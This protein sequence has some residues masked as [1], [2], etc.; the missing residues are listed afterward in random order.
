MAAR[1]SIVPKVMIWATW[2]EPYLRVTYEITSSRRLSSKSTSMSGG[3]LREALMKHSDVFLTGFTESLMTY[4]LGRRV[5]YFDMPTIRR[6]V[7]DASK[8]GYRMSSF[9]LGVVNSPAF[10]TSAVEAP[11]TTEDE[12]ARPA[13]R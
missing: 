6:I 8:N 1:A 9:V 7:R 12:A 4:A 13:S 5:E 10:R 2:S 3:S 11:A